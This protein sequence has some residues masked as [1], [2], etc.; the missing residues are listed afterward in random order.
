M[1]VK[2][3]EGIFSPHPFFTFLVLFMWMTDKRRNRK[4]FGCAWFVLFVFKREKTVV[5]EELELKQL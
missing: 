2:Y 5:Q 1:P 3:F 4:K